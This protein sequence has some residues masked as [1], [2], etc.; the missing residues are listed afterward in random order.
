MP[1]A[2]PPAGSC[3]APGPDEGPAGTVGVLPLG[4]KGELG[5]CAAA[6]AGGGRAGRSH[7]L[8]RTQ[9]A[10][11]P[12]GDGR[13]FLLL[14]LWAPAASS[15]A[16]SSCRRGRLVPLPLPGPPSGLPDSRPGPWPASPGF[17]RC[18]LVFLYQRSPP[19]WLCGCLVWCPAPTP[20]RRH[21]FRGHLC[22]PPVRPA[23]GSSPLQGWRLDAVSEEELSSLPHRVQVTKISSLAHLPSLSHR[24]AGRVGR[25]AAEAVLSHLGF[26][27]VR[28]LP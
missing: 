25:S 24:V 19:S 13:T 1:S 6:G 23:P 27:R 28:V 12:Q 20:S 14:R 7:R 10:P 15:S 11:R 22:A 4:G 17:L 21:G 2:T 5:M 8:G 16:P 18:S 3:H 9:L 26:A